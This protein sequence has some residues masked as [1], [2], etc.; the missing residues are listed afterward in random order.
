V[1]AAPEERQREAAAEFLRQ[2][3]G[4]D[5]PSV[6]EAKAIYKAAQARYIEG[7][8]LNRVGKTEA[9]KVKVLTTQEGEDEA[10]MRNIWDA[11]TA[12]RAGK[13]NDAKRHW[14][15]VQ[16]KVPEPDWSKVG[17]DDQMRFTPNK[18]V[19]EKRLADLDAALALHAQV[20]KKL[21]TARTNEEI[22]TGT[23]PEAKAMR[24]VRLEQ[25]KDAER[26]HAAWDALADATI[27]DLPHLRWF[28]L[29]AS[30]KA[31]N[32]R[33]EKD[34][35][36]E[37]AAAARLAAVT[38]KVQFAAERWQSAKDD[39]NDLVGPREVRNACR[40]VF[41]LYAD[42][43]SEDIQKRVKEAKALFAEAKDH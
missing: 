38:A 25:F 4:S 14:Q 32:P 8:I 13:L 6:G 36:R 5:H 39:K 33:P 24:A 41:D 12:E 22:P 28:L 29:A 23:D 31:A 19:A 27:A 35:D 30:Q 7:T 10:V 11:V 21:G 15:Y 26:A 37:A 18:W 34:A 17:D 40:E 1:K 20:T 9:S 2:Y 16:E 3:G 42:E 43:K